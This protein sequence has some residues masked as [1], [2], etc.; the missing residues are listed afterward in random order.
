[1]HDTMSLVSAILPV[2]SE[3]IYDTLIGR[4]LLH[5]NADPKSISIDFEK[6]AGND[7]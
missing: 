7:G 4:L 3:A 1:M 6:A 2:K 5:T